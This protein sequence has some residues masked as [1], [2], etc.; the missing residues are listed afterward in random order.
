MRTSA[1]IVILIF[2]LFL[3]TCRRANQAQYLTERVELDGVE[4]TY[5]IHLPPNFSK[6]ES[7]PLV[8][9]LH[10]GN[11]EGLKFDEGATNGTLTQAADERGVVLVFPDGID[12]QWCDGRSE[13][14]NPERDC[15]KVD[16][17]AFISALIDKMVQDDGI[18][19]TR[20][21]VTGI[22][23]G[24]FMSVRLAMDLSEKLAAVAPVA[25]QLSV[26]LEDQS[27]Q[28]PISIMIV[29]G[30]ADPLVPFEGGQVRVVSFGRSRGEIVSTAATIERFRRFN[31]C[32]QTPEIVNLPDS[33]P[34][35]GTAVS[36]ETYSGCQAGTEVIL[37]KIIGGGHAWP[38]GKQYLGEELVGR[39]SR[40]INASELILDFFLDHAR[41][42]VSAE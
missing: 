31:G 3:A 34:D 20:V 39:V 27:P 10:G 13:H 37:V 33:D 12:N 38:G 25:A 5:H 24:G 41:E 17:V 6:D 29:N 35:D 19:P 1:F 40:E 36:I 23:N 8:L 21:Y 14:L 4:R 30:T 2:T 18:D 32:E 9:V 22:S 15:A 26:A 28:L 16:D 11:G 42:K 7:A